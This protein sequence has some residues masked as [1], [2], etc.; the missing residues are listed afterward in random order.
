[1]KHGFWHSLVT[2]APTV[3]CLFTLFILIIAALNYSKFVKDME[4]RHKPIVFIKGA[5]IP[6]GQGNDPFEHI[7]IITNT[8]E[9]PAKDVSIN[10]IVRQKGEAQI[11][12]QSTEKLEVLEGACIYPDNDLTFWLPHE[13]SLAEIPKEAEVLFIINYKSEASKVEI[14]ETMKFVFSEKTDCRWC[15]VGPEVDVFKTR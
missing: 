11:K 8:G 13:L 3:L 4:L 6:E 10:C 5:I 14:S 12:I 9:L 1:M 15:Y 2:Y 7:F